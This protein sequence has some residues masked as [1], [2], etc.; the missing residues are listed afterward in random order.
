MTR[1]KILVVAAHPDDEVLGVGGT[2]LRHVA[3]GDTVHVMILAEG[4]TSRDV[5]RNVA[6]CR[7]ALSELHETAQRVAES[8]G[9]SKLFMEKFPDNRMDGVHLL[10]VVKRIE[11]VV[12]AFTPDIVY[13]HHGGDVNVD[14][15][16]AHDAVLTATRPVPGSAAPNLYFF[17]TLSSTEWQIQTSN[18]AF[19][20][21]FFV[22]IEPY[23]EKKLEVLRLY[24][25]E[26]RNYPH[27][28]SYEA[29]E[30]LAKLR[31]V[32]AGVR[33]AEAFAVGRMYW[34]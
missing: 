22:D 8:M 33:T 7:E 34:K 6:E 4:L 26:M 2:V 16:I 3:E 30:A 12:D 27:S 20:P 32:T 31:G 21:T 9:V 11:A 10:D 24:E 17:E 25:R 1:R 15:Q 23:I 18:R 5:T 29:V 28:R 14:H 19:L 13:T